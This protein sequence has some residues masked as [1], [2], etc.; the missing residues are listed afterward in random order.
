VGCYD[1]KNQRILYEH[2]YIDF[3][4]M[5]YQKRLNQFSSEQVSHFLEGIAEKKLK[6]FYLFLPPN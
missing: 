6:A 4:T 5:S 2:E 3:A 1:S